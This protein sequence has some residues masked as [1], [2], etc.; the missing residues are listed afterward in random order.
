MKVEKLMAF[1]IECLHKAEKETTASGRQAFFYMAFGA[2]QFALD[3]DMPSEVRC[4][5]AM[6]WEE[7][8]RPKFEEL[9]WG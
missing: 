5:I 1:I 3:H 4:A 7:D 9:I 6:G 8:Y 2:V